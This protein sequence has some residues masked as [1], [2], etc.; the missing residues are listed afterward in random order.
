MG[1]YKRLNKIMADVH[2]IGVEKIAPKVGN[3]L[4]KAVNKLPGA[5]DNVAGKIDKGIKMGSKG[6]N[7]I[8]TGKAWDATQNVAGKINKNIWTDES[9]YRRVGKRHEVSNKFLLGD[10][11]NRRITSAEDK[12]ASIFDSISK[13]KVNVLGMEISNPMKLIKKDEESLV[14]LKAT[15][16]GALFAAGA[17]MIA[18]TPGAAK[19][20]IANRQGTNMDNQPTTSAPRTPAYA[21]NGG[22]TG[23]LVFALNNLRHGGMM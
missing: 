15:K 8:K 23:D 12:M 22:A 4:N 7:A 20:Y 21:Q 9:S 2:Q 17:M 5:I 14:G 16:R 3:V 10:D 18:G 13:D 6:V 1:L 19:Q 11:L